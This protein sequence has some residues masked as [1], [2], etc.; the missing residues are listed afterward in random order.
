VILGVASSIEL[1]LFVI[2][3][4]EREGVDV[5]QLLLDLDVREEGVQT[6]TAVLEELLQVALVAGSDLLVLV[7]SVLEL[8]VAAAATK[9][10]DES[11]GTHHPSSILSRD[12]RP[13]F[14]LVRDKPVVVVRHRI[15]KGLQPIIKRRLHFGPQRCRGLNEGMLNRIEY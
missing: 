7:E 1:E 13:F 10:V 12:G 5:R 14:L 6:G 15:L 11:R 4:A 3:P 8:D 2:V 9:S